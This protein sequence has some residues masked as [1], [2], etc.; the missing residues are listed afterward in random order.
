MV[1]RGEARTVHSYQSGRKLVVRG[2]VRK[3][4]GTKRAKAV[5][6]GGRLTSGTAAPKIAVF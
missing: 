3:N 5:S 6:V 1:E 4:P 2:H